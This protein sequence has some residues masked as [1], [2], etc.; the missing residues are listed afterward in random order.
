M[1]GAV[2]ISPA[3]TG[4]DW[5]RVENSLA[6]GEPVEAPGHRGRAGGGQHP[7]LAGGRLGRPRKTQRVR[8]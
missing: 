4:P 2:G 1:E 3:V 5:L 8:G 7:E 6:G